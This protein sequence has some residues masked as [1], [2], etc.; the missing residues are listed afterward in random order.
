MSD[1]SKDINKQLILFYMNRTGSYGR[2]I[3]IDD[4]EIKHGIFQYN[5]CYIPS[6]HPK[7]GATFISWG[8]TKTYY[9]DVILNMMSDMRD[10]KLKEIGI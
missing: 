4:F 10:I 1:W 2:Q 8:L 6:I 3:T 5:S 9:N 7:N